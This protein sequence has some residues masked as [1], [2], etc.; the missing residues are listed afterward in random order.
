MFHIYTDGACSGNKK[1]E[2]IGGYGYVIIDSK[3]KVSWQNGGSV[4]N[5]TNNIMELMAA[6]ASLKELSQLLAHKTENEIC[7]IFSDSKYI[8]D[9]WNLYLPKWIDNNWRSSKGDVANK[10]YWEMLFCQ[11]QNYKIVR[12]DWVRGHSGHKQ[13]EA[14]DIIARTY[15]KKRKI[16]EESKCQL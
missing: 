12:F 11:V 2:G 7:V 13:N 14:A 9:G 15:A 16:H 10:K 6:I 3:N 8:I 5:T 1:N 4:I